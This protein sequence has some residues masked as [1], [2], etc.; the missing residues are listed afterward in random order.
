MYG[1]KLAE[2]YLIGMGCT[3]L[4]RNYRGAGGEIDL[5]VEDGPYV[6]FVEVKYRKSLEY[7][8]PREAVNASKLRTIRRTAQHY[9]AFKKLGERDYRFDVVEVLD[10]DGRVSIEWIKN[11]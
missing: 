11:V 2:D 1:Q 6:S 3:V 7:G 9:I 10:M 4:R 5:I 8:L